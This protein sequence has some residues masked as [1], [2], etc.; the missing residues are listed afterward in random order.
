M[1]RSRA[2]SQAAADDSGQSRSKRK[3]TTQ[4]VENTESATPEIPGITDGKK[5]T[6]HCNYCKSDISGTI[7]IKCALCSDFDLCVECF[8]VGAEVHPHKS[9][10][11]YRVMDNLA[12]PL[13]CP[14]WNADEEM[15]LLEGLEMYGLWNW[16]EVAEHVGTKS[17]AQCIDHYNR[18]YMNS[19]CFPLPDMSHVMGKNREELIAMA[20]ECSE[21]KKGAATSGEVDGK[22]ES[23]FPA[24]IK[25]ENQRKEGQAGLSSSSVSSEVDTVGASSCG[26]MSAGATE[27]TSSQVPA[28]DGLDAMKVEELHADRSVGEKKPRTAGDDG[29]SMKE[30]SG[31]NSKRQEFEIEYDNDA[32]QLLAD[33]EFKETD[34][35][36]ERELKLRVLHIYSKR[37]DERKRRKDFILERNLLYPDPFEKDLTLEEKE[38]CRHYR[39]FMRFHSKE[40]HYELLRSVV[41]E[42]RIVKR[43]QHLQEARAAGCRT[44]AE[45]E[46]YIEQKI[47]RE[48]EENARRVKESSQAG[49]SGKY[50]QR[51]NHHKGEQDTSPWG[52]N[53]NP[54]ILDP[55]GKDSLSNTGRLM[56]SDIADDWDVTGFEGADML[57]EAE[58]QLCG[59]IR[60]LPTHYLNMLQTMSMGILN[61]NLTK[62]SD[63]HGL[64]N[65]D[66]DKVDK[67]YDMLI[68]KGI[69]QA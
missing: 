42:H 18:T 30:L 11:S 28:N 36:A 57:S 19:P 38:L 22:E 8:S 16:S 56:G 59:E 60:I 41:A 21:T 62:K 52:G 67:V 34:T 9:N 12:F 68:R 4:N 35:D 3:R 51:V 49:P 44:S 55:G 65:V 20:K 7:R 48:T 17:K 39:V 53:N 23:L 5:A 33:M 1:G 26:K 31:Y 25:V 14:D 15:L 69:A 54:S 40:E 64:F 47:K 61:G 45:A 66:P 43:I 10:H 63:A 13:L 58:K 6:Y 29:V 32:E 46:R 50:L 2:V 24:R 37:L 27:R